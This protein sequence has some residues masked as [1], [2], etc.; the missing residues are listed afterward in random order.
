M[1]AAL[2]A[3]LYNTGTETKNFML[4]LA[5]NQPQLLDTAIVDRLDSSVKFGLPVCATAFHQR[6]RRLLRLDYLML[7]FWGGGW[8]GAGWARFL[9][10][11]GARGA[12]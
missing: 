9:H 5:S 4:V 6:K 8:G 1:R 7:L 2:N 10:R 12:P 11:T 3:F